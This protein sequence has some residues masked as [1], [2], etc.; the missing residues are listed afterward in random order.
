M[1]TNAW[2]LVGRSGN[3][4]A[5]F[6]RTHLGHGLPFGVPFRASQLESVCTN[7]RYCSGGCSVHVVMTIENHNLPTKLCNQVHS[8]LHES[9]HVFIFAVFCQVSAWGLLEPE[10]LH[11]GKAALANPLP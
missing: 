6:Y 10:K 4:A 3:G 7:S 9:T 11:S 2:C 5:E 1:K 8:P